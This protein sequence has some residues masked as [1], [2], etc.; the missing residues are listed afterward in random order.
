MPKQKKQDAKDAV[1]T[2][3]EVKGSVDYNKLMSEF[4][5]LPINNK[6]LQ[7]I[8]K[9]TKKL[10]PFLLRKIFFCHRDMD[11]ILDI[12]EKGKKF[13]I[14]T[15]RAPS[16]PVHIGH[17]IPWIFTK[18]LQEQFSATLLFQIPDEEKFLFKANLSLDECKKWAYENILDIIAVG[19]KPENTK[20]FLDTEYAGTMYK[21]A[22]MVGKK[23]TF[24]TAKGVFGFTNESNLGQIFYTCMQSV[25]A[26]LPSIY[27][28]KPTPCLI[29]YAIDQDPHFR[30][31]RDIAEALGYPKPAGIQ[32]R[33]L[34]GLH[35]LESQGKM[36]SSEEGSAI[37]TT[38]TPEQVKR[39]I[40]KYAFSGGQPTT[41][42]H[43]KIGGNPD[44]D[45]SYQWLTFFEED[46]KKLQKIYDDYKSGKLLTGELKMILINKLNLFLKK[47]QEA[48]EKA[49]KNVERFMIR[50]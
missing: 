17:L 1:V 39:K 20:I 21:Y 41:E 26:F 9:H 3:W 27:E 35:G 11:K 18:W 38:D 47:H 8:Q 40:I 36:S 50:D 42:E 10:H 4:G 2:P 24:S 45:I 13:Y 15:G 19:F 43:R 32:C 30:V 23:I 33:F 6:L 31:T 14:Y 16:G 34:P 46:D 49:K 22:C 29:P 12:Y 48:R 5:T 37:Y 25:P 7:R 44:I 28:Q